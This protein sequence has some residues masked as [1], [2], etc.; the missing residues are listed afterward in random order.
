LAIIHTPDADVLTN[1]AL[2]GVDIAFAG[3]TH[4]GQLR[5][6]SAGAIVSGCDLKTKYA[7]GLFYFEK[8]VLH[9][10]RGLGEGRYSPFRFFCQ[11]EAVLIEIFLV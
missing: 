9:V 8:F 6:P 10:S 11:P 4:G 7:A 3:H 2:N 1:M 5:L